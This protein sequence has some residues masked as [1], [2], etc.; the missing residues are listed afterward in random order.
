MHDPLTDGA[1]G[2]YAKFA[3]SR[4]R[5]EIEASTFSFEEDKSHLGCNAEFARAITI[6]FDEASTVNIVGTRFSSLVDSDGSAILVRGK[7]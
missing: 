1:F 3:H 7:F 6:H 5:L 4:S 2:I